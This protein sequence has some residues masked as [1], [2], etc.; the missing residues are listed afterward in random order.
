MFHTVD[1]WIVEQIKTGSYF[2]SLDTREN[3]WKVKTKLVSVCVDAPAVQW[4]G[5]GVDCDRSPPSLNGLV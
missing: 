3:Y 1:P 5:L 2:P 4:G